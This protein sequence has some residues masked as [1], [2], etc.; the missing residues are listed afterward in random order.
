MLPD[1]DNYPKLDAMPF[2]VT[3][4]EDLTKG[5][6]DV[7]HFVMG[8]PDFKE[9]EGVSLSLAIG[10]VAL[11]ERFYRANKSDID[12]GEENEEFRHDQLG[13]DFYLTSQGHG[14]GFWEKD[15][16]R[17][18]VFDDWVTAHA[19]NRDSEYVGDDGVLYSMAGDCDTD[20]DA[21]KIEFPEAFNK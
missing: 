1:N 18:E 7:L 13:H 21:L 9:Y 15:Y 6:F 8:N 19:D 12:E 2:E 20:I 3:C 5:Y 16:P 14:A 4:P 11:C 10:A 17:S